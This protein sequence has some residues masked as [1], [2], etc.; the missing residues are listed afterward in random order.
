MKNIFF[1]VLSS[2][3]FI[4]SFLCY[5]QHKRSSDVYVKG[6]TRSNGT[7]VQPHYRSSPNST[8]SDNFSEYGNINPYTGKEGYKH[9]LTNPININNISNYHSNNLNSTITSNSTII[10]DQNKTIIYNSDNNAQKVFDD[11]LESA[12]RKLD[13]I[14]ERFSQTKG[15]QQAYTFNKRYSYATIFSIKFLLYTLDYK[16]ENNDDNIDGYMNSKTV[17]AIMSFQA[18]HALTPDGKLGDVTI[19]TIYRLTK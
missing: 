5:S 8:Y 16:T 6:Y 4:T 9:S 15:Y 12:N 18:D 7:Y 1:F 3:L 2:F 10:T 19:S 11:E 17:L 13:E 14:I